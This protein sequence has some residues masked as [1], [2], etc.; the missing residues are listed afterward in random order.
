MNKK[1]RETLQPI[2][3]D[4]KESRHTVESMER[5]YFAVKKMLM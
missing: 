4:I 3:D 1:E 5:L 2:I